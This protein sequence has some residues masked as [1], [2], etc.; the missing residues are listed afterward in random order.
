MFRRKT[1][2]QAAPIIGMLFAVFGLVPQAAMAVNSE[3]KDPLWEL[4]MV[5]AAFS[6][7][8][9]PAADDETAAWGISPFFVYRGDVFSVGDEGAF[10]ALAFADDKFELD[11]SLGA[12]LPANSKDDADRAGMEDLDALFE[13]GPQLIWHVSENKGENWTRYFDVKLRAR[14]VISTDLRNFDEQGYLFE[15]A[16]VFEWS[17]R[18]TRN[19]FFQFDV[20]VLFG[21]ERLNEYFYNVDAADVLAGRPAYASDAGY[22][23]TEMGLGFSYP[24]SDDLRLFIGAGVKL[25]GGAANEDSPLFKEDVAY[26]G[27]LV[28]VYNFYESDARAPR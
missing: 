26:N 16:F 4:G 20:E 7:P 18:K 24:F 23:G 28:L 27:G 6:G 19:L 17:S 13:I 21:S 5:G 1:K 12:S 9:Y 22:I 10:R 11:V 3:I 14:S 8:S 25:Y 15:P 2:P